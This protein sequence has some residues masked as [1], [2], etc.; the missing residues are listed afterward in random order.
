MFDEDIN[1]EE[2][3]LLELERARMMQDIYTWNEVYPEIVEKYRI[4]N[5]SFEEITVV[6]KQMRDEILHLFA[7]NNA[8]NECIRHVCLLR[9]ICGVREQDVEINF[10]DLNSAEKIEDVLTKMDEWIS[11][12]KEKCQQKNPVMFEKIFTG[13]LWSN[14]ARYYKE[15][16]DQLLPKLSTITEC[17]RNVDEA[18]KN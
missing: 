17:K 12:V 1:L 9:E 14:V 18:N 10:D 2:I 13:D 7:L 15:A 4:Y 5:L 8:C 16:F 6:Y 11:S 3:T